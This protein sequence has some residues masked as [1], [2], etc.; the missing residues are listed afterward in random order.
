MRNV[1]NKIWSLTLFSP[2]VYYLTSIATTG[3]LGGVNYAERRLEA[4]ISN[5]P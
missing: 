1:M 4:R 5:I 2:F 3:T